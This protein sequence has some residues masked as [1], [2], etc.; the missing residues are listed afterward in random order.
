MNAIT[1][2]IIVVSMLAL[3]VLFD[4]CCLYLECP[5]SENNICGKHGVCGYDLHAKKARCYCGD[6]Y[7]GTTCSEF[8]YKSLL[9]VNALVIFATVLLTLIVICTIFYVWNKLRKISVNPDAFEN[10]ESKFNELGQM[11]Y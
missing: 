10:L 2:S 6:N 8:E 7:K 11:A 4:Y 5:I 1:L 3:L 9:S